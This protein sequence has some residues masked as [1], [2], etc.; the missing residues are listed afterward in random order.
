MKICQSRKWA[1][2]VL[3]LGFTLAAADQFTNIVYPGANMTHARGINDA[4]DIVGEYF[5]AAGTHGF[6]LSG[7]KFTSIDLPGARQTWARGINARGDIVGTYSDGTANHGFLLS[8]GK[9]TSLDCPG[10]GVTVLWG[11]NSAGDIAGWFTPRGKPAQGVVWSG[12][13]CN[14]TEYRPEVARRTMTMYTGIND[15]GVTVGHWGTNGGLV[16][17]LVYNKGAF[18]RVDHGAGGGATAYGINNAGDIVGQFRGGNGVNHGFL[19]SKGRF[20]PIDYPGAVST[21]VS[22]I[23]N[24]GQIVGDHVDSNTPFVM[25]GFVARVSPAGPAPPVLTVDDDGAD[26]PGALKTIQEA[27]AQAPAGA[28]ILVCT[29]AYRGTVNIVGP[30]KT[31]LKLIAN[32]REDEV[33]LQGDNT[34]RDGFHLENVTNVLIRGFTVR[35]F[36][37]TATTATDWGVGNQIYLE[38]AHYNTIE[39]NTLIN[40]DMM[41]IM[42]VDSGNNTIQQ[43]VAFVDN[44]SLANCGIHVGGAKSA[45]NTF[46]LN[47]TYGNKVAGIMISG[48]GPGNRIL[49]NTVLANGRAGITVSNTN[50]IWIEGNRVSY[51]RG[52]WGTSPYAADLVGQGLGISLTNVDKATVFDNRLRNNTGMDLSWDGRG[53]NKLESNACLT[54]TPAGACGR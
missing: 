35:D 25:H 6:L 21:G 54:S 45:N 42:L 38:N 13:V 1:A 33:V 7:G 22:G 40:G 27:V 46:R 19:L 3:G 32:G 26:C 11:I 16:T 12:G 20:R 39:H 24:S 29:G 9:F 43:N 28:T 36:G 5:D 53:D 17:G 10:D 52:P 47:M 4:G 48:A 49:D 23:N 31:G 2:A 18:T 41:G 44:A 8:Q 50:E 14:L 30:E 51:N 34:E 37:T 15:A